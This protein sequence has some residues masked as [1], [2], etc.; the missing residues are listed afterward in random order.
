MSELLVSRPGTE[1]VWRRVLDQLRQ[2]IPE[3]T[4]KIWLEPATLIAYDGAT[5]TIAVPDKFSGE[6][7]QNR[8]GEALANALGRITGEKPALKY[9]PQ[10]LAVTVKEGA[11]RTQASGRQGRTPNR[12]T[13]PA[14]LEPTLNSRCTFDSFV[15]GPG[16]RLAHAAAIAVSNSPARAYNPFFIYGSVGLGKTHLM[17][18]IAQEILS[19]EPQRK[20]CYMTSE[21]FTNELIAAIQNRSTPQFRN[22]YRCADVLLIDDVHFIA[23]KE[24]TQ[25]EVFHTF[26]ALHD[27]HKQIVLA[28][29]RP[30]RDIPGLEE[31]LVSRFGWGL[32]VDI[33]PPDFETRVAIL[34]KKMERETVEVPEEVS[35]FIAQKIRSNIRELEGALIRVLASSSLLGRPVDLKLAQDVLRAAVTEED[36]KITIELIQKKVADY[37]N[38]KVADLRMKSRTRSVAFPRQIAMYLVRELT[39]HSLAEI[40]DYF[41][42]RNH[43]TV[44]HA[45]RKTCSAKEKEAHVRDAIETLLRQI[46]SDSY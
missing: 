19:R 22:R 16:N 20:I 9:S 37:F 41:G 18:A 24:A 32:V 8:F 29:D 3:Q 5:A 34:K 26:N 23:G 40:G 39:S 35:H 12:L 2:D 31:R 15:I 10:P 13:A 14:G 42:G 36:Q 27:A 4:F 46:R 45:H 17:H 30:P 43:A 6:W 7:I 28:S 33:Q 38:L 1:D 44:L 21:K 25:L 11:D